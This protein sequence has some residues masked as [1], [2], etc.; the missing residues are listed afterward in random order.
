MRLA[1]PEL[2]LTGERALELR[3]ALLAW[4][5]AHHRD[6]PWRA[7]RDP[8]RI[9]VS[10]VM[11]Q[12]TRVDVA[13]PYYERWLRRFPDLRALADASEAEVLK[14][15]E[16]LGYY[17]RA[18]HLRHAAIL[19][20]D[21]FGGALPGRPE[22]LRV[23]PG[24]GAYTAA[25]VASIAFGVAT[26]AIDGNARR[27]L[28]RLFDLAIPSGRR[29]RQ[30]A[31]LLIDAERPGEFNQA[32]MELGATVCTPRSPACAACPLASRCLAR[33]RGS[34][35]QRPARRAAA[36]VPERRIGTALVRDA[37]GRVLLRRRPPRGLL[38]G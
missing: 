32:L 22:A 19:V 17:S 24:I 28:A 30:L 2:Q 20:R 1:V 5:E 15:W 33:T 25:A 6:L 31:G 3:V 14:A 12:Q 23:L 29:L 37:A 34:Q 8:Y 27:V 26:P 16:G 35:L 9:W 18:R 11:L 10:E 36:P 13:A 7:T 21:R 4:Y 38:G